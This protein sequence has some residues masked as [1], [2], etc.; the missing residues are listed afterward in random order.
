MARV[1]SRSLVDHAPDVPVTL[2]NFEPVYHALFNQ[3]APQLL[4][5]SAADQPLTPRTVVVALSE[6]TDIQFT[7]IYPRPPDGRLRLTADF[8]KRMDDG[9]INTISLNE[10]GQTIA[11]G[12]QSTDKLTW[13]TTLGT[14]V[15]LAQTAAPP[16]PQDNNAHDTYFIIPHF[17]YLA[18]GGGAV[19]IILLA[20]ALLQ[21]K[22]SP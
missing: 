21:R 13:E 2:D 10:G 11:A 22:S 16:T 1:P 4:E 12:S 8:I 19:I 14:P 17:G 18:L 7:F 3:S 15:K 6:E 9:Y 5:V 20:M